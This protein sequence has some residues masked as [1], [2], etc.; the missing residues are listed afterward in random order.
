MSFQAYADTC[1]S[2]LPGFSDW[3]KLSKSSEASS[4][5]SQSDESLGSDRDLSGL[6]SIFI[7]GPSTSMERVADQRIEHHLLVRF[8]DI[9]EAPDDCIMYARHTAA[10]WNA[11]KHGD[12]GM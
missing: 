11:A 12:I 5:A 8:M 4:L 2:L 7:D 3:P 1:L 10:W 9:K 6:S